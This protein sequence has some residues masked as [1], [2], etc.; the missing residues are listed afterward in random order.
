MPRFTSEEARQKWME[1]ATATREAKKAAKA[2]T[3]QPVI[4]GGIDG[5]IEEID[6]KIAA[7]ENCKRQLLH[8]AS[9]VNL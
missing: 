5:A 6:S 1:S 2:G 8:A 3:V 7:L 4:K 9:L